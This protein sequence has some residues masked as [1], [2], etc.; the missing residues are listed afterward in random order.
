M[1]SS[2]QEYLEK[3]SE[4]YMQPDK[5]ITEVQGQVIYFPGDEGLQKY[6]DDK[7]DYLNKLKDF[8]TF[9]LIISGSDK[10]PLTAEEQEEFLQIQKQSIQELNDEIA[11]IDDPIFR[12]KFI[13]EQI[14][15]L[16]QCIERPCLKI[17]LYLLNKGYRTDYSNAFNAGKKG[18]RF[19][20]PEKKIYYIT[21]S[22]QMYHLETFRSSLKN[23][24]TEDEIRDLNLDFS[25][26]K[27]SLSDYNF[28]RH[29]TA[30]ELNLITDEINAKVSRE[31]QPTSRN[32]FKP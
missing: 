6:K 20:S 2:P 10:T 27:P 32:S 8:K 15:K 21:L 18:V 9:A 31:A 14:E 29:I 28:P 7:T 19:L 3:F 24:L 13:K 17:V 30:D 5:R 26:L 11:K 22:G 23:K 12:K 1:D 16:I 4:E 25:N